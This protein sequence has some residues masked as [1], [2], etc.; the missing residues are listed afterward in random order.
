MRGGCFASLA[1]TKIMKRTEIIEALKAYFG[2]KDLV[3]QH[4]YK[5]FGESSWQFLDT[6]FLH[7]LLVIRRDI[8]QMPMTC[9]NWSAGGQFSQRGLRCN[10]CQLVKEKTAKDQIYLSAHCNG[11]AGDFDSKGMTALEARQEIADRAQLLPYPIR[12]ES[13]VSW[14]HFDCYDVMNGKMVSYFSA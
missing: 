2:V 10:V 12:M 7:C 13:E 14:L 11:A 1:M 4:T 9:N 3:C 5:A 8:L 6:E